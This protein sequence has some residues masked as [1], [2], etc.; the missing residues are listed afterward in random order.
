MMLGNTRPETVGR[1]SRV[2]ALLTVVAVLVGTQFVLTPSAFAQ[3]GYV[4]IS[5]A[6]STWSFNALDQWR[7]NVDKLNGIKVNFSPSGSSDGRNQFKNGTVD[8][9]VSEIEYG[10]SDGGVIDR[11]PDKRTFGYMPI[12]AGGTAFMYNLKVGNQRVT[13][14]RLSGDVIAKIFTQQITNWSDPAIKADNPGSSCRPARSFPWSDPTGRAPPPSSPG[15]WP[16]GT[17]AR[18]T[19][20]APRPAGR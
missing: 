2:A 4:P 12:V 3:G 15:G 18:G 10:L 5:G 13:N 17:P 20:T 16:P 7:R 6:G 8:F 1:L 14:L 9:A 11:P 19:P